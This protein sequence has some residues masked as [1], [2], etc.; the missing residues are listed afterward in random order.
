MTA[1]SLHAAPSWR[2]IAVE[3]TRA[4]G[5]RM[6][7]AGVLLLV[8][9]VGLAAA[10][11]DAAA[12]ARAIYE[13]HPG[14]G[15]MSMT[16]IT[17]SPQVAVI[18]SF[19]ALLVPLLVWEGEDPTRRLYHWSMP[20]G[21]PSHA[22]TKAL[23]GWLWLMLAVTVSV[24]GMAVVPLF[25]ERI[26]GQPQ[27]YAPHFTW[28]EWIV[29][30]VSATIAYVFASAAA[31]GTRQPLVWIFGSMLIYGGGLA[32]FGKSD[33]PVL[34]DVSRAMVTGIAGTYGVAAAVAGTIDQVDAAG[35]VA[36][37][38]LV[39]WTGAS[40]LWGAVGAALFYLTARRREG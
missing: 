23:G 5:L 25:V 22:V 33:I 27:T 35:R 30:F 15:A 32:L 8:I 20:V 7:G 21:Q 34:V 36:A 17:F 29:P 19:L 12:R 13:R 24:A 16:N 37:P 38:S 26:T 18:F 10:M 9:Q 28:W 11:L 4:V 39:R 1:I 2:V 3:Q 14:R 31:L 6:R 40:A